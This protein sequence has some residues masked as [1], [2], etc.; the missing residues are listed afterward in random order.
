MKCIFNFDVG[1]VDN[2]R[3]G[4]DSLKVRATDLGVDIKGVSYD[5]LLKQVQAKEK[6]QNRSG[7]QITLEKAF[8]RAKAKS[9]DVVSGSKAVS[10]LAKQPLS[11]ADTKKLIVSAVIELQM[12]GTM[13]Q[14]AQLLCGSM[15][16]L[17]QSRGYHLMKNHGKLQ[18]RMT[19]VQ[20]ARF[21]DEIM[22][23][24]TSARQQ[25]CIQGIHVYIYIYLL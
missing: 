9:K 11:D 20:V 10:S 2:K 17:P 12:M 15:A 1:V 3:V 8:N 21:I 16:Q 24:T 18:G 25:F 19:Q 14:V 7:V 22:V 5:D 23:S 13:M 6:L 4:F